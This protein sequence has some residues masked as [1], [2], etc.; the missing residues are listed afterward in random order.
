MEDGWEERLTQ[1][2]RGILDED[3]VHGWPHV[4]RVLE[5]ALRLCKGEERCDRD[6]VVA[7]VLL[8]DIGRPHE[9]VWGR[10]HALISAEMAPAIL[11]EVG[12]PREKVEK[13]VGAILAHSFSLGREPQSVEECVVRDADR[14]D[15]LGAVGVARAFMEGM[16]RGRGI[17]ETL[18]HFEEKLLR[19]REGMCTRGGRREAEERHTFMLTF[20]QQLCKEAPRECGGLSV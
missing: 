13:V 3:P 2:V 15:A 5:N 17:G 12:F 7:A 8:H 6:V 11:E 4:E 14:L 19:L 16:R 20:V 1:R 18:A 9:E 10:H